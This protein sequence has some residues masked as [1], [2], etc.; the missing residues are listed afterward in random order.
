VAR[1]GLE[2]T[3]RSNAEVY[4][5]IDVSVLQ[6][7]TDGAVYTDAPDVWTYD[8]LNVRLFHPST[9]VR[10]DGCTL[11]PLALAESR[12][13]SELLKTLDCFNGTSTDK[14]DYARSSAWR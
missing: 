9:P 4:H 2:E 12:L 1:R 10:I 6:R 3:L 14:V 7:D 8:L 11:V 5:E 13:R